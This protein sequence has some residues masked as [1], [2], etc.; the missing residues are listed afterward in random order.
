[1]DVLTKIRYCKPLRNLVYAKHMGSFESSTLVPGASI[2]PLKEKR[3]KAEIESGEEK[4]NFCLA[5]KTSARQ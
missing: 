5:P 3:T 2:L 1:M 4:R